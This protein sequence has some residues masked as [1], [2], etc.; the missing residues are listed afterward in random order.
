[1][2]T[3]LPR[4]LYEIDSE[5]R[6]RTYIVEPGKSCT[7]PHF[8]HR[9]IGTGQSCKHMR[10]VEAYRAE[11]TT[12]GRMADRAA[13]LTEPELK[14]FAQVHNGTP[15]GCACLLELAARKVAEQRDQQLK[16]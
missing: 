10:A 1:M 11:Q 15:A 6:D 8:T 2:I 13:A 3:A 4:N 14:Q 12:L 9:L 5:S 16:E 7:C